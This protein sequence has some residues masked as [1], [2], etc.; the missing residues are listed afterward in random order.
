MVFP[1]FCFFVLR[2]LQPFLQ[3]YGGMNRIVVGDFQL[4]ANGI[5]E[6]DVPLVVQDAV[7]AVV[8][9]V[10]AMVGVAEAA[11]AFAEGILEVVGDFV[12]AVAGGRVVEIAA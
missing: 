7:D 12:V 3:R 9:H 4:S 10:D 2:C 6:W 11:A 8:R 1:L 5:A